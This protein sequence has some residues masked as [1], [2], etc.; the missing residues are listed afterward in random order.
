MAGEQHLKELL[1]EHAS[2]APELRRLGA[3]YRHGYYDRLDI[4]ANARAAY[5]HLVESAPTNWM[6]LVVETTAERLIVDGFRGSEELDVELWDWWQANGLD[7]RQMQLNTAAGWAGEAY[8]SVW[9]SD[10][11]EAAP[12]IVPESAVSTLVRYM[13]TDPTEA[14][15]ALKVRGDTAWLYL[16]DV[17]ERYRR[18]E[19]SAG[20]AWSLDDRMDNPLGR[21]P[22]VAFRANAELDGGY[23]SDLDAAIPVQNRITETT[24]DRLL[25]SRLSAF[26]QRYAV[27]LEIELDDDGNP[28]APFDA[29]VDRLWIAEDPD[30]KFG[31]FAEATLSNYIGAVAADVHHLAAVTRT[32]PHYLLGQMTN[33]SAEA[34]AAAETGLARKVAERQQTYGEAW[35]DVMELAQVAD[36]REETV[37]VETVW[38]RTETVSD[39]QVVDAA[40]KL[41]GLGVPT[42]ALWERIGATP[43]Q[44]TRWRRMA[45]ADALRDAL[46]APLTNDGAADDT[47]DEEAPAA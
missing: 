5:R 14:T 29:A 1:D 17:V 10:D 39:A 24:V 26:R 15:D 2:R 21:V 25:A 30:V 32:P 22:F 36:G 16:P 37:S 3:Y 20:A 34:L 11:D 28:I 4:P 13:E 31:E 43:H 23:A 18:R 38:R 33:L 6:R 41:T 7:G 44:I 12:L 8:V 46:R 9:P 45:R 40:L 35:Q 27:G 47:D 42:E 19:G